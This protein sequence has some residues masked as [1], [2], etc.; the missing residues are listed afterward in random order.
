MELKS[1]NCPNCGA[2]I[3]IDVGLD[4]FF[5]KYCGQKIFLEGQ[6]KAAY[7]AKTR[8]KKM[9]HEERMQ[10]KQYA[11]ERF[12]IES[13]QKDQ[14]N[15]L[16][17]VL[18]IFGALAVLLTISSCF[19][20]ASVKKQELELQA[21]VDQIMIDIENE[22]FAEAYVKANSLYW[23]A[24]LEQSQPRSTSLRHSLLS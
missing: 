22:D 18:A 8:A 11:H 13:E 14:R 12:I 9:E 16:K 7:E 17:I 23:D 1:L 19:G 3:D 21:I 20:K 6:S 10:D 24:H 2:T 4:T 15:A 5:C